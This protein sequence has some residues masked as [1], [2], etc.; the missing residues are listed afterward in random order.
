VTKLSSYALRKLKRLASY[1]TVALNVHCP[2]CITLLPLQ[3]QA[4]R[5]LNCA[6]KYLQCYGRADCSVEN[7]L[8]DCSLN[9]D[10]HACRCLPALCN[11]RVSLALTG[12]VCVHRFH[13]RY[14]AATMHSYDTCYAL[15]SYVIALVYVFV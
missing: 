10:V 5:S 13:K 14:F 11:H 12:R 9:T 1:T 4:C 8:S 15:S 7:C 2:D 6:M 3:V